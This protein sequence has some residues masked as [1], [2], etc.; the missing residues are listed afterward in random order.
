MTWP[1]VHTLQRR[2]I[3]HQVLQGRARTRAR[4]SRSGGSCS[5]A[6]DGGVESCHLMVAAVIHVSPMTLQ[7]ARRRP[8]LRAPLLLPTPMPPLTSPW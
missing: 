7:P 2:H 3:V 6:G 5:G 4:V 8:F 1:R